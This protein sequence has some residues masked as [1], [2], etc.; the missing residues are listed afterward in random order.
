VKLHPNT[1]RGGNRGVIEDKD[2]VSRKRVRDFLFSGLVSWIDGKKQV[3]SP[4]LSSFMNTV[5]LLDDFYP[6]GKPDNTYIN[7]HEKK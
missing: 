1:V 3:L 4:S 7:C 6:V 5:N 2:P